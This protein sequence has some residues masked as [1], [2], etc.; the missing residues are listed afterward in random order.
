MGP[1]QRGVPWWLGAIAIGLVSCAPGRV[2][3]RIGSMQV[4]ERNLDYSHGVESFKLPNGLTVAL[5]PEPRANLIAV[6]V[7]YLVG[8]VEDPAG[9]SGLAHLV[10]HMMFE[11]R[12]SLDGPTLADRLAGAAL[13]HNA[14][15]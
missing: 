9:K 15:T 1:E 4:G 5:A 10:E 8:A 13:Y 6:D 3:L 11:R 7:R 2:A 14:A 12:T